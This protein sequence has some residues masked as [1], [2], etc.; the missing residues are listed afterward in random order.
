MSWGYWPSIYI[1]VTNINKAAEDL[2]E[3]KASVERKVEEAVRESEQQ[4]VFLSQGV[5]TL[6]NR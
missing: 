4:K 6:L 1:M 3:E 5:N 2:R